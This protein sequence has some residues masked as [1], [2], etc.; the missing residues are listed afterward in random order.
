MSLI[1]Y[2]G[3]INDLTTR[4]AIED[5]DE[6]AEVKE[7]ESL[8]EP[9]TKHETRLHVD[10]PNF[11]LPREVTT[12]IVSITDFNRSI[13][14]SDLR[15]SINH[16][17]TFTPNPSAYG[18]LQSDS[19]AIKGIKVSLVQSKLDPATVWLAFNKLSHVASKSGRLVAV[20]DEILALL[21]SSQ[22][23][24]MKIRLVAVSFEKLQGGINQQADQPFVYLINQNFNAS[25][26]CKSESVKNHRLL[27]PGVI[28]SPVPAYAFQYATLHSQPAI[29]LVISDPEELTLQQPVN[30]PMA[31]VSTL[32]PSDLRSL[33]HKGSVFLTSHLDNNIFT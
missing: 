13:L 31:A 18:K 20:V 25:D 12:I 7:G 15:S 30:S 4:N 33:L 27:P 32:I 14:S 1:S 21:L 19:A 9:P 22:V 3:E 2:F 29:A 16:L 17:A 10:P 6:E 8:P 5:S 26:F 23:A 28:S 11:Q 24:D